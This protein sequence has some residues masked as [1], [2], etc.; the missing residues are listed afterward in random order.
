[1][2][3]IPFLFLSMFIFSSCTSK[4][5]MKKTNQHTVS[6]AS[7]RL[8]AEEESSLFTELSFTRGHTTMSKRAQEDLRRLYEVARQKG[9]IDEV[10]VITWADTEYPSTD[11]IRLPKSDRR[12]V[13]RRNDAIEDYIDGLDKTIDVDR[14][15]MAERPSTYE[16]LF[17]TED[18]RV[19]RTLVKAGIPDSGSA[20][21]VPRKASKSIVI[22]VMDDKP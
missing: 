6:E 18:A 5:T 19:K 15:S 14:F 7:K 16:I 12:L 2:K 3:F 1:M 21:K 20:S 4:P 8:A 9:K 10:K 22:F 17:S 11:L 13:N